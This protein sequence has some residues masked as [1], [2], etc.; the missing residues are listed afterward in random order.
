[1]GLGDWCRGKENRAREKEEEEEEEEEEGWMGPEEGHLSEL[2][3]EVETLNP[4]P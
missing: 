3:V 1:V 4:K 2:G